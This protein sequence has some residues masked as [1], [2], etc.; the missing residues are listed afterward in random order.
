MCSSRSPMLQKTQIFNCKNN[1]RNGNGTP[2]GCRCGE[3]DKNIRG[4]C[5]DVPDQRRSKCTCYTS[6]SSC[7]AERCKCKGC[8]NSF[9][10]RTAGRKGAKQ[11]RSTKCTSSP[12][13]LKRKRAMDF[14]RERNSSISLGSWTNTETCL[15]DAVESFLHCTCFLPTKKNLTHSYNHVVN[16]RFARQL[17]LHVSEK[18][19]KQVVGKW[20]LEKNKCMA[21]RDLAYG[22]DVI[23]RIKSIQL[24]AIFFIFMDS[25]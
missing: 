21:A 3:G 1:A 9:G 2:N 25:I 5:T 23:S 6:D 16:S 24:T 20:N 19:K 11:K 22:V 18:T 17:Q 15:L 7:S 10:K 4:A 13:P 8:E 12:S 14:L